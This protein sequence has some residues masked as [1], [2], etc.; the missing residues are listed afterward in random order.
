MPKGLRNK[1]RGLPGSQY[2]V[3]GL[4]HPFESIPAEVIGMFQMGSC[5]ISHSQDDLSPLD[6]PQPSLHEVTTAEDLGKEERTK[7]PGLQARGTTG[8]VGQ[9]GLS[10][11][12]AARL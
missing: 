1:S 3:A 9:K 7:Q 6:S 2:I 8:R 4:T 11:K 12:P 5:V 10:S